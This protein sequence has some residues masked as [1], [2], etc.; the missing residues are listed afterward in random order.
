MID[1][2]TLGTSVDSVVATI[3]AVK[4]DFTGN[5]DEIE[6]DPAD[7]FYHRIHFDSQPD[8]AVDDSTIEWWAKQPDA[9]KVEVFSE[10]DRIPL[11]DALESLNKWAY[12]AERFW[13]NGIAFDMSILKHA[14]KSLGFNP[15]W[16]YYQAMD[17]RTVYKM[18]PASVMP[19][20]NEVAHHAVLDCVHQIKKLTDA[21]R[22]H[23]ITKFHR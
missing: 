23:K 5:Y 22:Y 18:T 12:G 2:E 3:A 1:L 19:S 15:P 9:A 21:L 17:A 16:R 13:A 4:F 8:R 11:S 14:N 20:V 10:E 6:I 7:I